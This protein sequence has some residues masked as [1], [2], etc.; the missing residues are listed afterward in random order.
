MLQMIY[1]YT[2]MLHVALPVVLFVI[3]GKGSFALASPA[4]STAATDPFFWGAALVAAAGLGLAHV[5]PGRLA[6]KVPKDKPVAT[7]YL[8]MM[9]LLE[10]S[11]V[12]GFGLGLL[13]QAPELAVPF[14]AIGLSLVTMSPPNDKTFAKLR[15]EST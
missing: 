7:P 2:V 14:A 15:G 6:R 13:R 10:L 12:A 3:Y 9:C 4:W 5:I 1:L 11:V 8:V